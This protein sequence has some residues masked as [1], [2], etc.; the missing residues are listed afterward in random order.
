MDGLPGWSSP[1]ARSTR[2]TTRPGR[3]SSSRSSAPTGS[4]TPSASTAS[5]SIRRGSPAR[6]LA[7]LLIATVGVEPCFALNALTFAGDDRRAGA[8][9]PG[10]AAARRPCRSRARV[11][12]RSALRY[13]RA[14]PR[15]GGAAGADGAGRHPR[16]QLPGHRCR[17][18]PD[19]ASTAAPPPTRRW[20]A[21]WASARSIGALVTGARGRTG[22]GADRRRRP[23]PSGCSALLAAA[24]PTLALEMPVLALLGAASVTFAASVNSTLQLAVAPEMRG[25]VMALYSVVFLGSTPIG[26]P[27]SAGC[28]RPTSPGRRC[29]SPLRRGSRRPG[30]HAPPRAA[31]TTSDP[32]DA[33]KGEDPTP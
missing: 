21:R 24:M 12:V 9:G 16:L 6:R 3:A 13:V 4:S 26:G 32:P 30:R 22:L 1:A 18:W 20:S 33:G 14:H 8:D 25:R 31:S 2:S 10:A 19:S 17:C 5:S 15:A 29:C 23:S 28:R 7:G 27:W 11:R